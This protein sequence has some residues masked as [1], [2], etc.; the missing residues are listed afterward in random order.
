MNAHR[1]QI[2]SL[3]VGLVEERMARRGLEPRSVD[4]R[5][6]LLEE[7]IIDSLEFLDLL[8]ALEERSGVE[9]DLLDADPASFMTIGGLVA[10]LTGACSQLRAPGAV[11]GVVTK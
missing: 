9:L 2:F 5:T 8:A 6:N 1:S 7:G 4:E 10:E 11:E 3:V